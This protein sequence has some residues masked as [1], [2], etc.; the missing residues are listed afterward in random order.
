MCFPLAEPD[1]GTVSINGRKGVATC[2][3]AYDLSLGKL[4]FAVVPGTYYE[5][6]IGFFV[7]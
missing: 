1:G 6:L 5:V 3:A 4:N 2:I 7:R